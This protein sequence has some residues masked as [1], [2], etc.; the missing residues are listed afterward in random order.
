MRT[1]K[2]T[3]KVF[4][5]YSHKDEVLKDELMTHLSILQ[6]NNYIDSWDDRMIT[7]GLE[8][9]QE[10]N[11][12]LVSADMVL[13]LVSSA[14]LDSDYCYDVELA[15]AIEWADLGAKVVMPII[16]RPCLW[17]VASFSKFQAL[18]KNGTPVT[19][20]D[21]QDV[22]WKE[23]AM[24]IYKKVEELQA[25]QNDRKQK[26]SSLHDREDERINL[27]QRE[28]GA[29]SL[30]NLAQPPNAK[31]PLESMLIEFLRKHY[32]LIFQTSASVKKNAASYPEFKLI[33]DAKRSDI[34]KALEKLESKGIVTSVVSMRNNTM[35]K[36]SN[37]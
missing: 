19:T 14:F 22:A 34:K 28:I 23:I 30:I 33:A 6:R 2:P 18:P 1:E 4:V 17:E 20:F 26:M 10:I 9:D 5:S 11:E 32:R 24:G 35:F 29:E 25:N 15:T 3:I 13:L 36:I 12:N 7:G 8:W 16:V 37:R 21:N 31:T 27:F